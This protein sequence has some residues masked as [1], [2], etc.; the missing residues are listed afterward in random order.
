VKEESEEYIDLNLVAST[1]SKDPSIE[2]EK[3][4]FSEDDAYLTPPMPSP[5]IPSKPVFANFKRKLAALTFS[6]QPGN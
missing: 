2:I 3:N 5:E 4:M 1:S 6:R